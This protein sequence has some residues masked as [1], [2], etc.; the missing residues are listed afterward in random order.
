MSLRDVPYRVQYVSGVDNLV[1]QFYI[2]SLKQATLYQRR[3]G[4]FNARAL[5]LAARGFSALLRKPHAK[6][7]L[8][9]SVELDREE[10]EVMGDPVAFVAQHSVEI[11]HLLDEP[12]DEIE[13]RRLGL[14]AKLIQEGRLEIKVAVPRSGGIYHEKAGI[15]TDAEGNQVAF[16]GSGNETPGGWLRNTE[17]F[18]VFTDWQEARHVQPEVETFRRLWENRHAGTDVVSL[19][20]AVRQRLIRFVEYAPIE[21]E[22]SDPGD[23]ASP[24]NPFEWTPELAYAFEATRLWNRHEFAHSE[25]GIRPFEHQDYIASTVLDDWPPRYLLADEVGLGKTIE[26]GLILRGLQGAGRIGQRLLILAPKNLLEQWQ[27]ELLT[28]F[29]LDAWRLDGHSVVAPRYSPT[30]AVIKEPVDAEN[31]FRSKPVLLVSSQLLRSEERA[32][33]V[34]ELEYDLVVVDE[35][36]HARARGKGGRRVTNRLLDALQMLRLRTQGLLLLTATPIQLD[37]RELWDLLALLE[38]P[39]RWQD[40]EAFDQFYEELN[41]DSPDWPFIFLMVNEA[42]QVWPPNRTLEDDLREDFPGV[43]VYQLLEIVEKNEAH[44]VRSLSKGELEALRVTCYRLAPLYRMVFRNTRELLKRYQ[45]EGRFHG[46]LPERDPSTV[47]FPMD[48]TPKHLGEPF[49]ASSEWGLYGRISDYLANAYARY[50]RVQRGLGFLMVTYQKR[51][52]SSF[53]A[54]RRSL[55]RR[56]ERLRATIDLESPES[57]LQED[58]E[59]PEGDDPDELEFPQD[60]DLSS[61]SRELVEA[62]QSEVTYIDGFLEDLRELHRDSKAERLD[63]LLREEFAKGTRQVIV[64][65]QFKDTVHYLRDRFRQQYTAQVG[66]FTGEGGSFWQDDDW[67]LCNKQKIQ[68]LFTQAGGPIRILFC[69]DAASEGLNLQSCSVLVNYD[70]PWNPMRIEQR[71]GRV[72]R[73]GQEASVV[74]VAT[75]LYEQT[76]ETR[77]YERCLE[78]IDYFRS[79][80][81]HLQPILQETATLIREASL[82]PNPSEREDIIKGV[83]QRLDAQQKSVAEIDQLLRNERLLR[84]Y[85]PRLSV[86]TRGI[87]ITQDDLET[88]LQPVLG[89]QGWTKNAEVWSDGNRKITFNPTLRD[90]HPTDATYVWPGFVLATLFRPRESEPPAE[91]S[92]GTRT[93]HRVLEHGVVAYVVRDTRGFHLVNTFRDFSRPEGRT[94]SSLDEVK[95]YLAHLIR[96]REEKWKEE[97]RK[98]WERR[99]AGWQYR[100]RIYLERIATARWKILRK[101]SGSELSFP[102]FLD[103]WDDYLR[104]PERSDALRLRQ[105]TRYTPQE[106]VVC[107]PTRGKPPKEV[108]R[109]ARTER[110]LLQEYMDIQNHLVLYQS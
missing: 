12:R 57:L 110:V 44:R 21:R 29:N 84:S 88:A 50:E 68:E 34:C 40:D 4:Y 9:C 93:V 48:G 11:L 77:V 27:G 23:P 92:V 87:P 35:A 19:P 85:R 95:R 75:M 52:T 67:R 98:A 37:R 79:A 108:P 109:S 71:I 86:T 63:D 74:R 99:Q 15:F 24:K 73:I 32:Q 45:A 16:N 43:N 20:E 47:K 102:R 51:L 65:S 81:G 42:R 13:K 96:E 90:S 83:D 7:Q 14:L 1:E 2:P 76:V 54:I 70:L 25:T 6:V 33:Q 3:T 31:P 107:R 46:S 103:S 69:T 59:L 5:A 55:E 30:D 100:V 89:A 41:G 18:H 26:T 72:D 64:F 39:G 80:L 8:L 105:L 104:D 58:D 56:R 17:S 62:A 97:Q 91:F 53:Y 66:S 38:L 82:A 10:Q 94:F 49:P 61:H 101:E 106:E 78:R 36:H 28:K 60:I 22:P